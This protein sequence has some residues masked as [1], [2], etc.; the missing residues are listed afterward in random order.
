MM[1]NA[2]RDGIVFGCTCLITRLVCIYYFH[3]T[4]ASG[5]H[6]ARPPVRL[7]GAE[8][9]LLLSAGGKKGIFAPKLPKTFKISFFQK[10]IIFVL[11][12]S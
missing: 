2:G 11:I 12:F 10:N 1:Q 5:S 7:T 3:I 4:Q 9:A 8:R 6:T